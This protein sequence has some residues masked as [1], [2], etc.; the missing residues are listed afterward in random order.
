MPGRFFAPGRSV[1]PALS[2]GSVR[3]SHRQNLVQC[4]GHLLQL[5]GL[6][7]TAPDFRRDESVITD[8]DQSGHHGL[9]IYVAFEEIGEAGRFAA[10]SQLEI[11]KVDAPDALAEGQNPVLRISVLHAV[12]GVEMGT[13]P[14][15]VELVDEGTHFEWAQEELV[16]DV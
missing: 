9:P 2:N 11:F 12:A 10:T 3:S 14:F 13:H 8:L 7:G 6:G 15:A 1:C 16:P 5:I 4:R